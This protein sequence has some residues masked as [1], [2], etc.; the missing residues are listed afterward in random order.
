MVETL[1]ISNGAKSPEPIAGAGIPPSEKAW[2]S[3]FD[4]A[5]RYVDFLEH[6]GTL[7]QRARWDDFHGRV[8]LSDSQESASGI[9]YSHNACIGAGGSLV[10]RLRESMSDF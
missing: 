5:H 10:W 1:S 2:Q 4:V 7:E 6:H 3:T 9:V 8:V